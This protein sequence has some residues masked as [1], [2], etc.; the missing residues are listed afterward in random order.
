MLEFVGVGDLHLGK[1]DK[2]IPG[3]GNEIIVAEARKPCNYALKNG[4]T[5]VIFYGDIGDKARLSYDDHLALISIIFDPRYASLM[6]WIILGNHDFDEQGRNSLQI[7]EFVIKAL[8]IQNVKIITKPL[9]EKIEGVR[10]NF[11]PY[12]SRETR[13]KHVNICHFDAVGAKRDNGRIIKKGEGVETD[14]FCCVGHLHTPH[15]VEHMYFSGTLYQTNFGETLPKA[16]HHVKVKSNMD[17]RVKYVP[18]DPAVKLYN[19]EIYSRKDFTKLSNNK[20]HLYK[21]FIHDGVKVKPEDLAE[22]PNVIKIN[23]FK[24]DKDLKV[25]LEEEWKVVDM[26]GTVFQPEED[27]RKFL[28]T[29]RVEEDVAKRVLKLNKKILKDFFTGADNEFQ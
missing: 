25:Q 20:N 18:N 9:E 29:K 16:F 13:A 19:Q 7:L 3:A 24:D 4:I 5:H 21:L 1:L 27:L 15:Q 22:Y 23:R 26:E 6:F 17:H 12:P 14:H 2:I 11:L 10:V 8:K 28:T